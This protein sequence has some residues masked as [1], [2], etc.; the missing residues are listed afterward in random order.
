M[1]ERPPMLTDIVL[2]GCG[3]RE[4]EKKMEG[5]KELVGGRGRRMWVGCRRVM[6]IQWLLGTV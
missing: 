6:S 1:T 3:V 2:L 5:W 4:R